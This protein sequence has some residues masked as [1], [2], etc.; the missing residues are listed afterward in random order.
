[1]AVKKYKPITAGMRFK[2]GLTFEELTAD[3][4][5]K[6]LTK[7][8]SSNAGRGANGRISVRR[9][10]GGHKRK[11]YYLYKGEKYNTLTEL[12]QA[13]GSTAKYPHKT[14]AYLVEKGEAE[15]VPSEES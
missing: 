5:H 1:M 3:Q 12:G 8:K 4:P 10:G 15:F 7:G 11:G 6:S 2:T 14:G 9:K 13:N